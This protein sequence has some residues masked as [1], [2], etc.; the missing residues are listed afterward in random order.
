MDQEV[1]DAQASPV[2]ASCGECIH[3]FRR[4]SSHD[5]VVCVPHLKTVPANHCEVC[6]LHAPKDKNPD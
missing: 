1:H 6:E 4:K 3:T 5:T 2:E